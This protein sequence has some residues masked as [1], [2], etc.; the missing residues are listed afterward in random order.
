MNLSQYFE[1]PGSMSRKDLARK[2]GFSVTYIGLVC[3]GHK[4]NLRI[5]TC[6]RLI[7]GT[8]GVVTLDGLRPDLFPKTKRGQRLKTLLFDAVA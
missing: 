2:T 6:L 3:A 1:Q 8:G 7:E 4:E 5:E